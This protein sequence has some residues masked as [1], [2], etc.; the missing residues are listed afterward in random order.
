MNLIDFLQ[1]GGYRLKQAT[2]KKMQE[3]YF[4]ILKAFVKHLDMADAGNFIISGCTIV[5][6]N[7][8]PGMLYIDGEL[9]SFAGAAG[10]TATEIKKN[11]VIT[12]LAFKNG[13]NPGV[14]RETNAIVDAAGVA[15]SDFV[16]IPTVKALV[17]ANITSIPNDIVYDS[18]YV[19]TEIN[20]TSILKD[21]LDNIQAGAQVNVTPDF[22]ITNPATPGYIANKPSG[23]L[24][25][26]LHK[27]NY[28]FSNPPTD[29]SLT[30]TFSDVGTVNYMVVG[31]FVSHGDWN[32]DNDLVFTI[33][34]KTATSFRLLLREVAENTQNCSFDYMLIPL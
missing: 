15:L 21:K 28:P 30:V 7:I 26:Y 17:W 3:S 22:L 10:T 20:F 27:A 8:T 4:E 5:G 19:H 12:N 2:F 11:V 16:R 34:D 6:A 24:L 25:T 33:K 1:S 14:F 32:D 9:C 18:N 23:N 29:S 13:T 31:S